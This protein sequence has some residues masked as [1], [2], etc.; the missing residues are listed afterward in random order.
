MDAKRIQELRGCGVLV[1]KDKNLFTIKIGSCG[2]AKS[3][4]LLRQ[5]AELA[6]K[7]GDGSVRTTTR[8]VLEVYNVPLERVEAAL[9]FMQEKDMPASCSGPRLRS[10][11]ACPGDPVCRFSIGNTQRLAEEIK[12]RFADFSGLKTKIKVAITGCPNS[13]AKPKENCIGLMAR[14]K[15]K[16]ELSLGGKM[17]RKPRLA[18]FSRIV[19]GEEK[20]YQLIEDVL[21]WARENGQEKE[22]LSDIMQRL[23]PEF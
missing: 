12:R 13:C 8:Q 2:G 10:I 9:E 15:D 14:G 5:V 20:I 21:I 18:G 16:W 3:A 7:F 6:D 1:Q 17:G 22:R 11:V 19:E 23:N 4:E